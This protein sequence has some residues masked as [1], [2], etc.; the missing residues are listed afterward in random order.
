MSLGTW[1]K[2]PCR[3]Q[4]PVAVLA[5]CLF[6]LVLVAGIAHG[7]GEAEPVGCRHAQVVEQIHAASHTPRQAGTPT[8]TLRATTGT[9]CRQQEQFSCRQQVTENPTWYILSI[10]TWSIGPRHHTRQTRLTGTI[11]LRQVLITPHL[12]LRRAITVSLSVL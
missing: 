3:I 2:Q 6:V 7:L 5:V 12:I 9:P 10:H 1:S 4:H 8:S 11:L